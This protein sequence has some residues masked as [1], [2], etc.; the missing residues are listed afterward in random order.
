MVDLSK[1]LP[2]ITISD[3]FL[4]SMVEDKDIDSAKHFYEMIAKKLLDSD[5]FSGKTKQFLIERFSRLAESPDPF[6]ELF[7]KRGKGIS[8]ISFSDLYYKDLELAKHAYF[9]MLDNKR[10]RGKE[11]VKSAFFETA[12]KFKV[13]EATVK[14]AYYACK[15]LVIEEWERYVQEQENS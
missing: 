9:L 3:F 7:Y 8:K 15:D 4:R 10:E 2:E 5:A 12:E 13:D 1:Y 11:H 6:K 14:K